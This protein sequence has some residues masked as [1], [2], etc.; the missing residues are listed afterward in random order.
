MRELPKGQ[1]VEKY[2][3]LRNFQM[4]DYDEV[5]ALWKRA[6]LE[7][8]Q[9]DDREGIARKLERAGNGAATAREGLW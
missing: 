2:L 9:S 1:N 6:G 3:R 8:S 5:V 4:E 7:L